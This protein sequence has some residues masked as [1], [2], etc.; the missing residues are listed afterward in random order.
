MPATPATHR[1]RALLLAVLRSEADFVAFVM[2]H[3]GDVAQ[4]FASGQDRVQK[5]NLLLWHVAGQVI[6]Q[7]LRQ[8]FPQAVAEFEAEHGAIAAADF[9]DRLRFAHSGAWRRTQGRMFLLGAGLVAGLWLL[10]LMRSLWSPAALPPSLP[11]SSLPAGHDLAAPR[12]SHVADLAPG[13]QPL[14]GGLRDCRG[15]PAP[16]VRLVVLG[17]HVEGRSDGEGQFALQVP[18]SPDEAVLLRLQVKEGGEAHDYWVNLGRGGLSLVTG[19]C[20]R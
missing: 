4:R 13:L 9:L 6:L 17:R 2:D 18:G 16:G 1:L 12:P 8:A 7:E 11:T 14:A 15:R 20:G 19:G 5:T 10:G 3:H